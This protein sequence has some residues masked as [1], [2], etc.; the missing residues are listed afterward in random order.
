MKNEYAG[1]A[2]TFCR[3]VTGS[4]Y[5]QIPRAS[6]CDAFIK[7]HPELI[8]TT[9]DQPVGAVVMFRSRGGRNYGNA[10][11]ALRHGLML[12]VSLAGY[13]EWATREQVEVDYNQEY[14]GW[15]ALWI[16]EEES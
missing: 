10:F 13:V 11:V 16:P 12:G 9:T 15:V 8:D 3:D 6:S 1:R 5:R 4:T 14:A 7:E 2:L